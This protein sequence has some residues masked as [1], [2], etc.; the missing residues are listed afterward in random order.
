MRSFGVL[1][2]NSAQGLWGFDSTPTNSGTG[3]WRQRVR[4]VPAGL[5]DRRA[6]A[7]HAGHAALSHERAERVCAGR[8]ARDIEPDGQ[9]GRPLRRL[10]PVHRRGRSPVELRSVGGEAARRRPERRGPHRGRQ[11]GLL[12]HRTAVGLFGE[13]A[14][15]MVLRGGYGLAFY[16]NNKNAGAYMK[17][18]PFTANYGPVNEQRRSWRRAQPVSEGWPA[19]GGVRQSLSTDRQC[20]RHRRELQV[21]S[22]AAVQPHAREGV[23][24]ER[25]DGRATSATA[26]IG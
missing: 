17:N 23:R 21:R 26:P 18:P 3:V 4:V 11:D 19:G 8:L 7:V 12:E 5:P 9:P 16:P 25:R 20:D 24:R 13:S 15:Q 10:Y 6:P 22:R 1:Q 14:A 2:S